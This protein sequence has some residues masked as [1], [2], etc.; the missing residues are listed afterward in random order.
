MLLLLVLF[1]Y[2]PAGKCDTAG[3]LL[4]R[5]LVRVI[6]YPYPYGYGVDGYGYGVDLPTRGYTR[7][8]PYLRDL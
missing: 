4:Y 6:P 5:G 7:A 2:V 1:L 8:I 3:R